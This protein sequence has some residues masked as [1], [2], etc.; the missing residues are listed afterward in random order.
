MGYLQGLSLSRSKL[1]AAKKTHP[2]I[3]TYCHLK[4]DNQFKLANVIL[5]WFGIG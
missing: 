3:K 5:S 2:P 4:V 1:H